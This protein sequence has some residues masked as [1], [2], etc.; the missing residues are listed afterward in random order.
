MTA[1]YLA[2]AKDGIALAKE[3]F[4]EYDWHETISLM[5]GLMKKPL[6]LLQV[7]MDEKDDIFQTQLLMAGRCVAECEQSSH[8]LVTEII[9]R[10]YQFWQQ[11]PEA[12]FIQSVVV[13]IGQTWA[14]L[15]QVLQNCFRG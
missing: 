15:V 1:C 2:R 3:H 13:A 4:W 9:N 8:P 11:Y 14:T 6:P 10:I 12:E 7:M 5:A